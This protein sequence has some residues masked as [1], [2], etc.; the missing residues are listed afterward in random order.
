MDAATQRPGMDSGVFYATVFR[1]LQTETPIPRQRLGEQLLSLQRIASD[2]INVLPQ[3]E[4]T[5]PW[6]RILSTLNCFVSNQLVA[7]EE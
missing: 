2:K 6:Q 7:M 4:N 5:S 3:N 1:I